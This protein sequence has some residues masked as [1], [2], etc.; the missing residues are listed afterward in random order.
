MLGEAAVVAECK[1]NLAVGVT[2]ISGQVK[3]R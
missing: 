1:E 3:G 2:T